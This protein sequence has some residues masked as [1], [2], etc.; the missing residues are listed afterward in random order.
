MSK[1]GVTKAG[2]VPD[3]RSSQGD[4]MFRDCVSERGRDEEV[5]HQGSLRLS[6]KAGESLAS[7]NNN[8]KTGCVRL[9]YN[10]FYGSQFPPLE[11]LRALCLSSTL[12]F[13]VAAFWMLRTLRDPVFE[14]LV[15]VKQL[16]LARVASMLL[17]VAM[18]LV[19]SCVLDLR[20]PRH[21][22]FYQLGSIYTLA[23]GVIGVLLKTTNWV[24]QHNTTS[25]VILGWVQHMVVDSF[26]P[27]LLSLFWSFANSNCSLPMAMGSYGMLAGIAEMG[28]LLGFA[29][30]KQYAHSWGIANCFL[31][32]AALVGAMQASMAVYAAIYGAEERNKTAP[33]TNRPCFLD[34]CKLF[35]VHHYV[36]GIL[37]VGSLHMFLLT[38][39][40]EDFKFLALRPFSKA[41]PCE[42]GKSCFIKYRDY[43]TSEKG[44]EAY[45]ALFRHFGYRVNIASI[46]LSVLATSFLIRKLGVRRSLLVFPALCLVGVIATLLSPTMWVAYAT[47]AVL[48]T[49]AFCLNHPL[50][51][52]LY[53]PTS[54]AV[55]YKARIWMDIFGPRILK[56]FGSLVIEQIRKNKK[57]DLVT[58]TCLTGL[59][60]A[61]V[62]IFNAAVVGSMFEQYVATRHVVGLDDDPFFD[63]LPIT[64]FDDDDDDDTFEDEGIEMEETMTEDAQMERPP[65]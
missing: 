51:E 59:V 4:A 16:T 26:G 61:V 63:V 64:E 29:L 5:C 60:V 21:W 38:M 17:L 52:I 35:C 45:S 49:G 8:N 43:P 18:V 34:G 32:A 55:R 24:H 42:F 6:S 37:V 22:L 57:A 14:A 53:Q 11:M 10:C 1:T 30:V 41:Y 3:E 27:I 46:V 23:F 12:F 15:E 39:L 19:Y 47:M 36:K 25:G 33:P 50:M 28:S 31:I 44:I 65:S 56:A 58:I 2:L 62:L 48:K 40:H 7:N 13:L 20:M 9:V 54:D